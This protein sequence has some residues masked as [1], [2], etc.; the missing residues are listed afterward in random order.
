MPF[1]VALQYN[2]IHLTF[3]SANYVAHSLVTE[4]QKHF[5]RHRQNK[6]WQDIPTL[7]MRKL[8]YLLRALSKVKKPVGVSQLLSTV[9][10][11]TFCHPYGI[12]LNLFP[13]HYGT[14][15]DVHTGINCVNGLL[16]LLQRC[17]IA[18]QLLT[19]VP[20]FLNHHRKQNLPEI[21]WAA[22]L[23]KHTKLIFKKLITQAKTH[24]SFSHP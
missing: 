7:M 24:K 13:F 20:C 11:A 15:T 17:Q 3:L 6:Y 1:I 14:R 10:S 19:C 22:H 16:R 9:R 5:F 8:V 12:Q 2:L 18:D 4:K 23:F 21:F